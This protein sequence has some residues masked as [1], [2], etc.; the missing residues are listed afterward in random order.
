M[1]SLQDI[2]NLAELARLE[3][4]EDECESAGR[5]L[6]AVLAYVDRLR[7]IDTEGVEP[8]TMPE[9]ADGWREDCAQEVDSG[10]RTRIL[11][12]FPVRKGDLLCTPGVFEKPKGNR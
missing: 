8:L 9:K 1:S 7:Q 6:R 2:K 11:E 5:D 10:V 4:T 3:L 12:N